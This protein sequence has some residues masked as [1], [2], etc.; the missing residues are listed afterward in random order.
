MVRAA[1]CQSRLGATEFDARVRI[2]KGRCRSARSGIKILVTGAST[3]YIVKK[4]KS[5]VSCVRRPSGED[6][7]VV[8]GE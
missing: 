8:F 3:T 4:S 5:V 6:Q 7:R 1:T 2:N